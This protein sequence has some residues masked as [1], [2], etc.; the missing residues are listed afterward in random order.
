MRLRTTT[1][2]DTMR[3]EALRQPSATRQ[4]AT[5]RRSSFTQATLRAVRRHFLGSWVKRLS[6]THALRRAAA[7]LSG[8]ALAMGAGASLLYGLYAIVMMLGGI[9]AGAID[10]AEAVKEAGDQC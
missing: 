6:A 2:R 7:L 10:L 3:T 5:T 9:A 8:L 4:P 1:T